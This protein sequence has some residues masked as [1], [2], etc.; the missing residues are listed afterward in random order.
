MGQAVRGKDFAFS[1]VLFTKQKTD[2]PGL[3]V[4]LASFTGTK[5]YHKHI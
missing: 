4:S 1:T 5:V 3:A 2:S